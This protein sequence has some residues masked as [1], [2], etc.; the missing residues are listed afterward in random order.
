MVGLKALIHTPVP[1]AALSTCLRG[2][3]PNSTGWSSHHRRHASLSKLSAHINGAT[4]CVVNIR[5]AMFHA[6]A[7]RRIGA[8]CPFRAHHL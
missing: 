5:G 2:G 3:G 6:P 1:M 7:S 8:K 4:L